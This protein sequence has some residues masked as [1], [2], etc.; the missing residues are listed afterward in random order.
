LIGS[1]ILAT[2]AG[3]FKYWRYGKSREFRVKLNFAPKNPRTFYLE[4]SRFTALWHMYNKYNQTV[5]S[6]HAGFLTWYKLEGK[7]LFFVYIGVLVHS[8][9]KIKF[10][11]KKF[12]NFLPGTLA[13]YRIVNIWNDQQMS[14]ISHFANR[15]GKMFHGELSAAANKYWCVISGRIIYTE[16]E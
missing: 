2:S 4:L 11:A 10:C 5:V 14:L 15:E 8:P 1:V 3:H 7:S 16:K 9:G 13:F 6:I 12:P